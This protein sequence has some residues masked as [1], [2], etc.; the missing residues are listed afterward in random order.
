MDLRFTRPA[1]D[2]A[3]AYYNTY[4][5][6]VPE[7]DILAILESQLAPSL[8]LWRGISE[9][10]SLHRYAEGKWSIRQVMNHISDT[11]RV[12]LFRAYWFARN[13]DSPLPGM[14]QEV[15]AAAAQADETGWEAHIEEF[16]TV[17]SATLS[18]LRNLP[19]AAWSARGTASGNPV[20]TRA[21]IH[22]IAGHLLHH[23]AILRE[24]YL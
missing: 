22:I 23:E 6:L 17:R 8:A 14:D 12:M 20:S 15:A 5:R 18:L 10:K 4:L 3:P 7:G 2:E 16:R 13:F 21:L 9:E 1:P 11:E 19:A 24:R